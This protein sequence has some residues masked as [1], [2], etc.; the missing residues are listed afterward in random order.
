MLDDVWLTCRRRNI[1][2]LLIFLS[3][4]RSICEPSSLPAHWYM[5]PSWTPSA[6]WRWLDVCAN[7]EYDSVGMDA[8]TRIA[9]MLPLPM[10][11]YPS[12][13]CTTKTKTNERQIVCMLSSVPTS[14]FV[15]IFSVKQRYARRSF[16]SSASM[17]AVN[18]APFFST[19]LI[20]GSNSDTT[21]A[22]HWTTGNLVRWPPGDMYS[23]LAHGSTVYGKWHI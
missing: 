13:K 12:S 10:F 18:G 17:D 15:N 20:T 22:P 6:C 19:R 23:A 5:K 8:P 7:S 14:A 16:F 21:N 4:M 11:V 3:K 2:C 1:H 9:C